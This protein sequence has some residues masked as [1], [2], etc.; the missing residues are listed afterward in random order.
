MTSTK[1]SQNSGGKWRLDHRSSLPLHAQAEELL[2]E[3][4]QRP[5]YRD[6][7]LLPDEISLSRSLGISRN[8]LRAAIGRLVAEGRLKRKAGVGT[9]VV[10]ARVHSGVGAWHSFT[11]EMAAKGI[12]VETHSM[13][14]SQLPA[15][16]EIARALHITAGTEMLCLDRVRGWDGRAEVHFRSYFHPRLGLTKDSD[17][18][19][20]LYELI[21]QQCSIVADQSQ[22]EL[23][24][25]NADRRLARLLAVP[26]GTALLRRDR[27]V[28]DTGRRPM[29]LAVVHYRCERFT[30]TLNLRQE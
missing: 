16:E 20:P 18:S 28:L 10:E 2:R 12:K 4:M 26:V 25:V 13:K 24:A 29:E 5:Q 17:F 9:R 3:L 22:E 7:G 23:K 14:V 27:T 6:G 1:T 21:Q 19:Q 30:L 11:H 15:T 8:T